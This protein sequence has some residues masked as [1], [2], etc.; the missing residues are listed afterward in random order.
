MNKLE[1]F[2]M[3]VSHTGEFRNGCQSHWRISKWLSVTH[4]ETAGAQESIFFFH[5]QALV[6]ETMNLMLLIEALEQVNSV[7]W[8]VQSCRQTSFQMVEDF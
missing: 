7:K 1:N 5:L 6:A 8:L 4:K 3:V 2:E